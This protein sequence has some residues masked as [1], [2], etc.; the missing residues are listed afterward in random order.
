ML[1]KISA[2]DAINKTE[3]VIDGGDGQNLVSKVATAN[4]KAQ[5]LNTEGLQSHGGHSANIA[6]RA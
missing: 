2:Q 5:P 1:I 3:P 6:D 4:R